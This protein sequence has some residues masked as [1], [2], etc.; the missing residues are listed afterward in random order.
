[1]EFSLEPRASKPWAAIVRLT[2][3]ML[4]CLEAQPGRASVTISSTGDATLRVA[5][6]AFAFASI[7]EEVPGDL[8]RGAS[9]DD[10]SS[11]SAPS[12]A[13]RA[14]RVAGS[15]RCRLQPKRALTGADGLAARVKRRV[16]EE[17]GGRR[18]RAAVVVE[19]DARMIRDR[20]DPLGEVGAS[21]PGRATARTTRAARDR[22][23]ARLASLA[24]S[25]ARQ[26]SGRAANQ[27]R[28]ATLVL[29]AERPLTF[30]ALR[31]ALT[32]G[33]TA[34]NLPPPDRGAVEATVKKVAAIRA[35]GRYFLREPVRAEARELTRL[36]D[37]DARDLSLI[38]I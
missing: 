6:N 26:A 17:G 4:A 34:A 24:A 35:P 33:L 1:M 22:M 20:A 36:A 27:L 31:A 3:A 23:A 25:A 28:A 14:L 5:E 21:D 10:A 38:H 16:A 8:V 29:L 19:D 32:A 11:A 18:S 12:D 37:R 7:A 30:A 2:P 9:L 15:L 13:R